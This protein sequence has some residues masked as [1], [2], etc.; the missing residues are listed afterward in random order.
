MS[1]CDD[2]LV[3]NNIPGN[4]LQVQSIDRTSLTVVLSGITTAGVGTDQKL[5]PLLRRWDHKSGDPAQ[6]GAQVLPDGALPITGGTWLDLEDGVQIW[7]EV[8]PNH[9][10]AHRSAD[11]WLIPARVATGDV[12]WP[13]DTWTDAQGNPATGPAAV[14]PAGVIHHY[15]SLAVVTPGGEGVISEATACVEFRP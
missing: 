15:V 12:I 6:G 7:F 11:Y 14:P 3:L 2:Y 13:A 5:H 1:S 9:P 10:P 4:L 8:L